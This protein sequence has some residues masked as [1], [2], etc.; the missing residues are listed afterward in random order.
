MQIPLPGFSFPP[1]PDG[2]SDIISYG[3]DTAP[4]T[5]IYRQEETG[6]RVEVSKSGELMVFASTNTS[7]DEIRRFLYR[8]ATK[9]FKL[10]LQI[11]IE[12]ISRVTSGILLVRGISVPYSVDYNHRRKTNSVCYYRSG[13]LVVQARA[14]ATPDDVQKTAEEHA[15]W[16]YSQILQFDPKFQRSDTEGSV[17]IGTERIPYHIQYSPRARHMTIKVNPM[18]PVIVVAPLDADSTVVRNFV[19]TNTT[20]IAEKLGINLLVHPIHDELRQIEVSGRQIPY[21]IQVS[22]RAK[23]I[24]VKITADKSV[25]V[26][27]PAGTDATRIHRFIQEKADWID[28]KVNLSKK[29][30]A[31]TRLFQDGELIPLLGNDVCLSVITGV[32]KPGILLKEGVIKVSIPDGTADLAKRQVIRQLLELLLRKT[33]HEVSNPLIQ[34]WSSRLGISMP[35]V[36]YGNQKTRWGVC[37]SKGIILNIRLA[38]APV[39]LIEYVVVHELCHIIHHNHSKKFWGLVGQMLPD[40]PEKL[41]R[42]KHYGALYTL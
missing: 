41:A 8:D 2:Y 37:T 15:E 5:V 22:N 9:I 18:K 42:L 28:E 29:P 14:D 12:Q 10:L 21:R 20:W 1:D 17:Q 36:K 11:R 13:R 3:D 4:Y 33:I 39:D 23:R 25:V 19:E 35:M 40:Y 24:I 34:L 32:A 27:I 31:P 30:A 26:V 7:P 38:M 16:I 6:I